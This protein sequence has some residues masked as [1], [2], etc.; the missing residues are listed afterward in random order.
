MSETKAAPAENGQ[1][2]ITELRVS[3]HLMTLDTGTF[4][5]FH[6]SGSPSSGD[7]AL[8]LPG[9]R[10]SLPPGPLHNP[11]AV[12]ISTFRSDGWLGGS[13]SAALIRVAAGQ[14]QVLVTIYQ[15][16]GQG[17]EHA[18]RLQVLRLSPEAQPAHAQPAQ[19]MPARPGA[20]ANGAAN[21]VDGKRAVATPAGRRP[22]PQGPY[23]IVLHVQ[24][25]GDVTGQIGEWAG[26][27]GSNNWIEGFSIVPPA[28]L[29]PED[30]EY[31]AVLGRGWLSP[32][33]NGGQ[34]CGSRGMALPL[35]GLR[36][37]LKGDAAAKYS[38]VCNASFIDGTQVGP[39]PAGAAC[40][41]ESMAPLEAFQIVIEPNAT[42]RKAMQS[43]SSAKPAPISA[44]AKA[45]VSA[46]AAA[47]A[48][49]RVV[50]PTAVKLLAGK[51]PAGKLPAGKPPAGKTA[52][53][54]PAA[55]KS[56]VGT[57]RATPPGRAA[58]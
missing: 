12:T 44:K 18:P 45:V 21:A 56:V 55:S 41:A 53:T 16:P 6:A 48:P 54:K 22:D 30:I 58:R 4:C 14:A 15:A 26:E 1:K 51:P 17:A 27:R 42:T 9:V 11:D 28:P 40:E 36:L 8:G 37:R 3:G 43:V 50:K 20:I 46:K 19:A 49:T 5:V 52:A 10:I 24:V 23:D 35:L 29:K 7:H 34:F 31:Q 2:R 25:A 39:L 57:R 32:W 13:D 33:V 38:C 47:K